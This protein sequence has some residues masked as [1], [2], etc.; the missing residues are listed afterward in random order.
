MN[1]ILCN[2]IL[3]DHAYQ[4]ENLKTFEGPSRGGGGVFHIKKMM[5]V[6]AES[7]LMTVAEMDFYL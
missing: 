3:R 7:R 5:T 1:I 6:M 2:R 4:F